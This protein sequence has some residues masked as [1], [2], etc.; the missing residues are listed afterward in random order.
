MIHLSVSCPI[1]AIGNPGRHSGYPATMA[2][3]EIRVAVP[4]QAVW[5][6][7]ADGW[8]YTVWVVGTSH[9]RAVEAGWPAPGTKLHHAAG[10][11]PALTRDDTVVDAMDE[12]R[13]LELTAHGRPFGKAAIVIELEDDGDG[14]RITMTE[15]PTSPVAGKLHNPMSDAVLHRRNT[16]ALERLAALCER[17]TVPAEQSGRS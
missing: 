13:R 15:Y 12:G 17:R 7:L 2:V 11:W 4:R 3:N 5:D 1:G 6:V 9:M 8:T 14:C 10:A 16:E